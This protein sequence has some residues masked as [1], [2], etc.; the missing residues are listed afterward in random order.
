MTSNRLHNI[1]TFIDFKSKRE[2]ENIKKI[3]LLPNGRIM[4]DATR[5]AWKGD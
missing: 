5:F 2:N 1:I 4:I 3:I